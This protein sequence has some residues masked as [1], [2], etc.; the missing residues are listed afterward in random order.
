MCTGSFGEIRCYN[1]AVRIKRHRATDKKTEPSDSEVVT[2]LYTAL[3]LQDFLYLLA[4]RVPRLIG[5][6][7]RNV[8]SSFI[9]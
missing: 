5:T 7:N 3:L 4:R 9:F 1:E 2:N 8:Q 6:F